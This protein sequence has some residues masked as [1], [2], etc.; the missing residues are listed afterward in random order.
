[1]TFLAH[2]GCDTWAV[3]LS[4]GD[5]AALDARLTLSQLVVHMQ[6]CLDFIQQRTTSSTPIHL[7]GHDWGAVIAQATAAMLPD[8]V[9]SIV[10]VAVPSLRRLRTLAAEYAPQQ[11]S[12]S[13]FFLFFQWPLLPERH[14][15]HDLAPDPERLGW[16]YGH[17]Q[18]RPLHVATFFMVGANDTCMETRAVVESVQD[19]DFAPGVTTRVAIVPQA[20][21]WLH[22]E[23]QSKAPF[24]QL[25]A[26][27]IVNVTAA[28]ST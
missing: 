15:P 26:E 3:T 4:G 11:L 28:A 14:A 24:H 20:G 8:R 27:W 13:W 25:L 23:A 2:A 21:H 1:M 16:A 10:S 17:P 12:N 22:L 5:A 18:A 6:T 19:I 7:I 9:Q